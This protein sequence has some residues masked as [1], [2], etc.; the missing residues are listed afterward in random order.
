M[1]TLFHGSDV[2]SVESMVANGIDKQAARALGGGDVFWATTDKEV[3]TL[4]AQANPK[5]GSPA[6]AAF[7]IP[8]STFQNLIKTGAIEID[9]TGA[10]MVKN[11]E[12]F[13]KAIIQKGIE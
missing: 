12:K 6:V 8:T 1:T 7:K 10:Y 9:R 3:A 2:A 13:N 4:F 5:G 11:W